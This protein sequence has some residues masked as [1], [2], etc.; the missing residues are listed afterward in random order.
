MGSGRSKSSRT[1]WTSS[2]SP[3]QVGAGVLAAYS[4]LCAG[5]A[6]AWRLGVL[7]W[8]EA[9]SQYG[10]APGPVPWSFFTEGHFKGHMRNQWVSWG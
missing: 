3:C 5:R 7:L 6:A 1:S 8:E 10:R 4:G 2:R 9:T